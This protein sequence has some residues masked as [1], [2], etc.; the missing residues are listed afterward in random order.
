MLE[1]KIWDVMPASNL[2][3]CAVAK[4]MLRPEGLG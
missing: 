3:C 1:K 4:K 2:T